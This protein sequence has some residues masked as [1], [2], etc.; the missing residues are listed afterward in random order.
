MIVNINHLKL[1]IEDISD[2]EALI[3]AGIITDQQY[4]QAKR[5]LLD[6]MCEGD[7]NE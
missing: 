1:E 4:E 3:E 7:D 5:V 6:K 2:I